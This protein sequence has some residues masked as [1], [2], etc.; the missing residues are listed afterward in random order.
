[1][2]ASTVHSS[3]RR[4]GYSLIE[5][6]ITILIIQ[7]ISTMVVVNVSS[8]T[9]GEKAQRAAEQLI[10]A[11]RYARMLAMT[12]GTTAGVEFDTASNTVRVFTGST[13]T[14]AANSMFTNNQ[15]S[16]DYDTHNDFAG[17]RIIGA[18]LSAQSTN[19]Y[20]VTYGTLGGTNNNGF[21][22]IQ[23]GTVQKTVSIPL[24][25]EAKIQ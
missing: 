2:P 6:L 13:F 4:R 18:Q 16:F 21:V 24:V 5:M 8:V 22:T 11:T 10:Y 12:S 15:Y 17:T 7:I 25:G 19:P 1:M 20:R 14:T 23:Y 9:A 3:P